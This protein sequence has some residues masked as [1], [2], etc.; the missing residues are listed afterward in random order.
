MKHMRNADR[1][2]SILD[3]AL[4]LVF[5][6]GADSIKMH[7]VAA[8]SS[9]S[10]Q[11][12]YQHFHSA[13]ELLDAL[14]DRTYRDYLAVFEENAPGRL[15]E[16]DANVA[17]LEGLLQLP[18]PIH[19]IVSSAFF[20]GPNGRSAQ[21]K[22]QRRLDDLID[23]NWIRPLTASGLDHGIVTSGVYTIFASALE[24]RELIDRQIMTIETVRNQLTRMFEFLL[25]N[26]QDVLPAEY[27]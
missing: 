6:S 1:R 16:P 26:P 11:S 3:A 9:V 4:M 17:P 23:A 20:A 24:C 5:E 10:R 27:A 21:M 18:G 25:R 8:R 19:R 13:D 7:D 22:L 15:D 12:L 2:D 14:Y